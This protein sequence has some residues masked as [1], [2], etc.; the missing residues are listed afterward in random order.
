VIGV[1]AQRWER[2]G[3][4]WLDVIVPSPRRSTLLTALTHRAPCPPAATTMTIA[5][6]PRPDG[7]CS[8]VDGHETPAADELGAVAQ[9]YQRVQDAILVRASAQGRIRLHAAVVDIA[10]QRILLAGH[11]GSGKSTLAAALLLAGLN[12]SSDEAAFVRDGMAIPLPRRFHLRPTTLEHLPD[13]TAADL[14]RLP[15]EPPIWSLDPAALNGSWRIE[16]A[17]VRHVVLLDPVHCGP[18]ELSSVDTAT[19]VAELAREAVPYSPRRNVVVRELA[20][21]LATASCHRLRLGALDQAIECLRAL[22]QRSPDHEG[23]HQ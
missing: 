12:V 17:P 5:I 4:R 18:S 19:A 7:W 6:E 13:L 10:G 8:L 2:I 14:L 20:T 15:Y 11:S 21:L 23:L 16:P 3:Y 1:T 9:A 22:A